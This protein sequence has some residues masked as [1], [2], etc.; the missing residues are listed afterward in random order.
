METVG[1]ERMSP[2]Y[3][4]PDL[5][6][7]LIDRLGTTVSLKLLCPPEMIREKK[8]KRLSRN[9]AASF[10]KR[11]HISLL[12]FRAG[13][14]TNGQSPVIDF[15]E[16]CLEF[17]CAKRSIKQNFPPKVSGSSKPKKEA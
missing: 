10:G 15:S 5:S 11:S 7:I 4:C 2:N 1:G 9:S 3:E 14:K 12:V 16:G 8:R 13:E 6:H 17:R